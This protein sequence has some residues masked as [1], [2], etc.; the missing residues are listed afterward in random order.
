MTQDTLAELRLRIDHTDREL[1]QLLALR[2]ELIQEVGVFK[3]QHNV[4]VLQPTRWSDVLQKNIRAGVKLGL[5]KQFIT[6]IWERIHK[7]ALEL[8]GKV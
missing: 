3:K 5:S 1:L 8:E 4:Q 7:E 2:Q 6:D